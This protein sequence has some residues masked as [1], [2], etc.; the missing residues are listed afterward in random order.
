MVD[1][2]PIMQEILAEFLTEEGYAVDI[3]RSGEEGI[4]LV[5]GRPYDCAVVDLM[6]PGIDGIQTTQAFKRIDPT[7]PVIMITAY[8][9][10]NQRS[11]R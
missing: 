1:D 2:E 8:A 10:W 5:K 6:M 7:L 11:R 3:A 4:E 9:S